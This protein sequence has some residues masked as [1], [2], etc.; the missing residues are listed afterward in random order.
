MN[1]FLSSEEEKQQAVQQNERYL[2]KGQ[3]HDDRQ[4]CSGLATESF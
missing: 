4:I 1:D 3:S 2:Q